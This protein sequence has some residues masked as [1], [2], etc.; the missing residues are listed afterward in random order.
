MHRCVFIVPEKSHCPPS[1]GLSQTHTFTVKHKY[2][3]SH[4][5][6][7]CHIDT[8]NKPDHPLRRQFSNSVEP[9]N[10]FQNLP[11]TSH[12]TQEKMFIVICIQTSGRIYTEYIF[13]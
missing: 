2:S 10:I 3:H 8:V 5:H 13:P 6:K 7:Y 4:T 1:A 9:E 11:H 12:V